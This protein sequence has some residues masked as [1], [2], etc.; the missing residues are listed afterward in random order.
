STLLA[1]HHDEPLLSHSKPQANSVITVVSVVPAKY[2]GKDMRSSNMQKT[3]VFG[4]QPQEGCVWL[5]RSSLRESVWFFCQTQGVFGLLHSSF[6]VRLDRFSTTKGWWLPWGVMSGVVVP[7]VS[8]TKEGGGEVAALCWWRLW[9]CYRWW[10]RRVVESGMVDLI[11][12][13]M[14]NVFGVRRKRSPKKFFDGDGGGYDESEKHRRRRD[15][16]QLAWQRIAFAA[17]A[18]VSSVYGCLPN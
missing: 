17:M 10:G 11:D 1:Y 3:G 8:W 14:G 9:W 7:A 4:G 13:E 16:P 18:G 15:Y 12:R 6:R 2:K 5:T